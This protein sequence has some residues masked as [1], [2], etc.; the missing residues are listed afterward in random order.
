MA[1]SRRLAAH[2]YVVAL[3]YH[4]FWLYSCLCPEEDYSLPDLPEVRRDE[5]DDLL[6]R[7]HKGDGIA[8]VPVEYTFSGTLLVVCPHQT[9]FQMPLRI[10]VWDGPPPDDTAD[11]PEAFE[12]HLDVDPH[13]L[14]YTSPLMSA[15][16]LD[17]PPGGYHAV[18][19][20][21]GFIAR[22]NTGVPHPP[23]SWRIRVWPSAGPRAARRLSAWTCLSAK[24]M[25]LTCSRCSTWPLPATCRRLPPAST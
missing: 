24:P 15:V 4:Q 23:D 8:Q 25:R 20:G 22:G 13:G 3:D 11:W 14:Y 2:D 7:A 10:E 19:T 18:I 6:D 1:G 5:L 12:A 17:V 9:N 16:R 21:R